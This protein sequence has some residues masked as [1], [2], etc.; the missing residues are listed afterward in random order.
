MMYEYGAAKA[1]V[2]RKEVLEVSCTGP[3]NLEA[4]MGL[5]WATNKIV[6]RETKLV[7]IDK[8]LL[9]FKESAPKEEL[10]RLGEGKFGVIVCRP[11]QLQITL[12]FCASLALIGVVRVA[13][14]DLAAARS[15]AL[16]FA[17]LGQ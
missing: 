13:F 7:R 10:A 2:R 14:L 17:A 8:A 3:M 6:Q 16:S 1:V 4:A 11:D 15:L 5:S 9:C 12:D